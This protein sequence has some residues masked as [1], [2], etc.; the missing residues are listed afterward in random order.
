MYIF[1]NKK[2]NLINIKKI[3]L[4][5][6]KNILYNI[7]FNFKKKDM[8]GGRDAQTRLPYKKWNRSSWGFFSQSGVLWEFAGER[9][10]TLVKKS[11]FGDW[12]IELKW[13]TY[14][15]RFSS[16]SLADKFPPLGYFYKQFPEMELFCKYFRY[17]S[18]LHVKCMHAQSKPSVELA[19]LLSVMDLP[20]PLAISPC[21]ENRQSN[22]RV[23]AQE[24]QEA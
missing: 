21:M 22:W 18:V 13:L 16:C 11:C 9:R 8:L 6:I 2:I 14:L 17:G 1:V 15:Y 19:S 7:I 5:V 12:G 20:S 24:A 10:C 3:I 4:K 23:P